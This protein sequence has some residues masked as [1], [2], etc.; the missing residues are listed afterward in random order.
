MIQ[1]GTELTGLEK[2]SVLLMSLGSDASEEV[3][4]RLSPEERDLLGAQIVRMRS[5]KS[6]VRERSLTNASSRLPQ[7]SRAPRAESLEDFL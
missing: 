2:A 6:I 4:K 7:V 3:L 5:V 1:A